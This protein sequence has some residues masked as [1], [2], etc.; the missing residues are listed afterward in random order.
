VPLPAALLRRVPYAGPTLE[1][2]ADPLGMMLRRL[3]EHGPVS[4]APFLGK[5][6]TIVVGPDACDEVLRNKDKAFA[7]GPGW[8]ELVG[9]FFDRGL[10]LLDFSEHLGHRRLMQQAFTRDRLEEYA[11]ALSPAIEAGVAAWPADATA[12]TGFAAYPALKQLT[13]DLATRVFLGEE[14]PTTPEARAEIDRVN[15]AFVACV[16][17]ATA[18]VRVPLPG[19]RWGRAIAGRALLEDFLGRRLAR[20]RGGDPGAAGGRDLFTALLEAEEDGG[21]RFDDRAVVDHVV[22]LLMAAHDTST[23]TTS[24]L[25]DQLGRHPDWQERCRADALALPEHPTLADLE[26]VESLDLVMKEALRL[27]PP[28]PVLARRTVAATTVQGVAVPADRLVAV[29]LHASHHL[30]GLWT[31]PE[32]FDPDRFGPERREDKS[33]QAAWEPFG[34]GVHKCLG[35]HFAGL[36]IKLL[37]VHLLRRYRW[38]TPATAPTPLS[39]LSLPVP[40]DGLPLDLVPRAGRVPTPAGAPS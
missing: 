16:Q 23:L 29:M 2:V 20:R 22:F 5:T 18:F 26:A 40:T 30:P 6:W 37:L 34:G 8:G 10:M 15:A 32:R 3:D 19:T 25:L 17:A 11:A 9:P 39:Y 33:H 14:E 36:E 35:M 24:T 21:E 4:H 13:L 28:V 1:Y 27:V 7:N 31:D 12:G 38:T